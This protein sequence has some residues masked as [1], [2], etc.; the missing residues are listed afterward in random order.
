MYFAG[1]LKKITIMKKHLLLL[2]ILILGTVFYSCKKKYTV[3]PAPKPTSSIT[4]SITFNKSR[5]IQNFTFSAIGGGIFKT[6][7]GAKFTV[8][9]YSF[10]DALGD[11]VLSN[12]KVKYIEAI[13]PSDMILLNLP[14]T[15][16]NEVL[17]TGGEFKIEFTVNGNPVFLADSIIYRL[18]VQIPTDIASPDMKIYHGTED[19]TGFV[20]WSEALDT[21][22]LPISTVVAMDSFTIVDPT[23]MK[24]YYTFF[25]DSL[26]S[27]WINCDYLSSNTGSKTALTLSLP[28]L[29][30]N[31]NTFFFVHFNNIQSVMAGYFD[32]NNFVTPG[33]I[34]VGSNVTLVIFSEIDGN[35]YSTFQENVIVSSS[36]S[37]SITPNPTT[38]SDMINAIINL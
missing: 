5:A 3:V 7:G 24:N 11:T 19:A 36:Y 37:N 9:P 16:N 8:L 35:Y 27:Q 32:G 28:P 20:D 15:A 23:L 29:H 21:A 10:R 17:T 4:D 26:S 25:L 2:S 38:Y 6:S 31:T 33:T 12:V 22:G 18:I 30:D 14:T 13:T 34:P 1:V